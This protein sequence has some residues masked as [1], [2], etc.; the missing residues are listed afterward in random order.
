MTIGAATRVACVLGDPVSHSRSPVMH[1]AASA[2][3]GLDRVYLALRVDAGG[4]ATGIRGLQALGFE[5]A[6]VTVPHKEAAWALC[7]TRSAEAELAGA[8]NTLSFADGR[9]HGHL[10]DGLGLVAA[11]GSIPSRATIVG[12]GGSAR[13][14]A[15]ALLTAGTAELH[16]VARNAERAARL[17][18]DLRGRF[19]AATIEHGERAPA[20]RGGALVH[21]TPIGGI[22]A[23]EELPIAADAV[24]VMDVVADFA[25]RRDG[26]PTPLIAAALAAGIPVVDGLEL[27]VRQGALAFALWT[28]IDPPLD[29]MRRAVGSSCP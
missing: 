27:L 3:L 6:N 28:G 8:A 10:T 20:R 2:A 16:V 18:D 17:T 14:A 12:A 29:V 25:Y 7:D 23:L 21:C 26:S 22:S 11:L 4:L 15:A 5:G 9:V 24:R 1:N 19:P 13:A